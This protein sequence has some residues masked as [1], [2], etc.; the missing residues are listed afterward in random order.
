MKTVYACTQI[1]Q[2]MTYYLT[3]DEDEDDVL[4]RDQKTVQSSCHPDVLLMAGY[5]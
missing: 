3:S 1:I 2:T 5:I 4:T